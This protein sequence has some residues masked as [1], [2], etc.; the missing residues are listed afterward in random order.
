MLDFK[1]NTQQVKSTNLPITPSI[2]LQKSTKDL[3]QVKNYIYDLKNILGR[4]SMSI[5]YKGVDMSNNQLVGVKK[6]SKRT[7]NSEY[8][9]S[10]LL[11]EISIH[12]KIRHPNIVGLKDVIRSTNNIY[13]VLEYCNEGTLRDYLK[14]KGKITESEA[15]KIISHIIEGMDG[16]IQKD[17]IHRDIKPEN[18]LCHREGDTLTFKICDFGFSKKL[19][20]KNQLLQSSIGSPQYMDL[21]RLSSEEYSSKSDVFS[22]GIIAYEMIF[23]CPPWSASNW[24]ELKCA[25]IA[26]PLKLPEKTVSQEME[27]FLARTLALWEADRASWEEVKNHPFLKK[28]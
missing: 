1:V 8:L 16:L 19:S 12:T 13:L 20:E 5:V 11:N 4:G 26:K 24:H 17:I 10:S 23:G 2:D 18:I 7:L 6:V 3:T 21:Q 27:N 9:I 28:N 22:L 14:Q 15:R 25:M